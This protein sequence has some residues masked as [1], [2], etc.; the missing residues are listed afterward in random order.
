MNKNK[1]KLNILWFIEVFIFAFIKTK[2]TGDFGRISYG[3]ISFKET[4]DKIPEML[5]FSVI[6]LIIF[7]LIY[8]ELEKLEEKNIEA[9]RKRI[10]E[11]EKKEKEV[12]ST[13]NDPEK[14]EEENNK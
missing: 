5:V 6:A 8:R 4:I 10:E 3:P 14:E 7:N 1:L 12:K 9:A 2:L 11:R 13:Q